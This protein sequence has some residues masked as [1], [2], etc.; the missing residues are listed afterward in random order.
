MAPQMH[1]RRLE[2]QDAQPYRDLRL[3]GLREH[4]QAFTSSH[5]EDS[6]LPLAAAQQRLT[7]PHQ[8]FWGAY[9]GVTLCGIVGLD[10]GTRAKDRH[11]ATVVGM[12][13][14]PECTGKGMGRALIEALLH[15][16]R[17]SGIELLVLTVTEGNDA[18]RRLYEQAGFRSFGIEPGAVRIDGR[19]LAKN[20]MYLELR[21]E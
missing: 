13:V 19:A 20:H 7:S 9:D 1:I 11:K 17:K 5:E 10:V 14:A 6:R 18:A 4:P 2:P 8:R 21:G 16:A 15:D 12:F 3:R